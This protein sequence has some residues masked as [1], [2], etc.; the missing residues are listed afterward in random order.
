MRLAGKGVRGKAA[1]LAPPQ[2]TEARSAISAPNSGDD[3]RN[4]DDRL[5]GRHLSGYHPET[6]FYVPVTS[7]VM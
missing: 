4:L 5:D 3:F 1:G 2:H 6:A 7:G